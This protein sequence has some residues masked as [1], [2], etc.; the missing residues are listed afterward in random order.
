VP[1][2]KIILFLIIV[3]ISS[4][5]SYSQSNVYNARIKLDSCAISLK[6][7]FTLYSSITIATLDK[8]I[9]SPSKYS[10]KGNTIFFETDFCALYRGHEFIL[11]Y[12]YYT[13]GISNK[14]A[15]LD[16]AI[17]IQ[18]EKPII[19]DYEY[20]FNKSTPILD[21][22]NMKYAGSFARG[23]SIGNAQSLVLNS[24]FD[25]QLSG[26]IGNG[27]GIAAAISD[28]NIPIQAD[29]N[30]QTLQEF[31]RVFIKL[32][33]NQN[34]VNAGDYSIENHPSHFMRYLK[35]IKGLGVNTV[36]TLKEKSIKTTANIATS[37]G[38]FARHTL[39]TK[40]GNQGPYRLNGLNNERFI[41]VLSG[42]EKVYLNGLLLV[43]GQEYDYVIDYNTAQIT[44]TAN[45][46]ITRESRIIVEYE[47]TDQNYYR[48]IYTAGTE[49]SLSPKSQ[50]ILNLYSEQ[51]SKKSISQ[52]ELDT[53]E[54]QY[55][56][57]LQTTQPFYS[58]SSIRRSSA[59]EDGQ[60]KY[61]LLPNP[62]YPSDPNQYILVYTSDKATGVYTSSFSE[63][64]AEKGS[65][66]IDN[67]Q[68]LNGRVYKYVGYNKGNY[69][70]VN[71]LVPPE[72]KQMLNLAYK[73]K[74]GKY[75]N[76]YTD[77]SITNLDANRY[78]TL[79]NAENTGAAIFFRF[80]G[81]YKALVKGK[82]T[83]F[84]IYQTNVENTTKNFRPLNQYRTQEFARDW[85]YIK[86]NNAPEIIVNSFIGIEKPNKFKGVLSYSNFQASNFFTGHNV[87]LDLFYKK[88]GFTLS[89]IPTITSSEN[90]I[91]KGVFT[92]PNFILQQKLS[93]K[94]SVGV[95][96]ESETNK[97]N[98]IG[99][100]TLRATSYAF[101]YTKS[102][103]QYTYSKDI[104]F[105][106]SYNQRKDLF[107]IKTDLSPTFDI[108]EIE[109]SGKYYGSKI[110]NYS[111]SLKV[112]DYKVLNNSRAPNESSKLT[113]L[114]N[115]DHDLTLLK[116]AIAAT[117]N[118]QLNSGQEPK[119]EYVYQKIENL[120]GEYVYVGSDTAKIKNLNDFR[121]DPSNPLA[122]YVRFT[123]PNNEF[124][125]TNN[126]TLNHSLRIEPS[127][128]WAKSEKKLTKVQK[129]ISRFSNYTS[130][131]YLNKLSSNSDAF[132]PINFNGNDT[133]T[134]AYSK[135]IISTL[136]YNRGNPNFDAAFVYR[137]NGAK[138]NQ[139]NGAEQRDFIENEFKFRIKIARNCD[140]NTNINSGY[141]TFYN[142]L[143][144]EREYNIT[145]RK[146]NA[147]V[148]YRPTT[149]FRIGTN[150]RHQ[151]SNQTINLLEKA[152]INEMAFNSNIRNSGNAAI[153]FNLSMVHI[154]YT[155]LNN[156]FVAYDLLEGL[157]AGTN[158][159]WS[160]NVTKR[161]SKM[162]D[163]ILRYEGRK[164]EGNETIHV[165]N[166]QAKA[167]F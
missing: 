72:Q 97:N 37:R 17:Q 57:Q 130:V 164:V 53:S 23:F 156:S 4:Y 104:D 108:K 149:K 16:T 134:V 127:L 8:E 62:S 2:R 35:K 117:T 135:N 160:A 120:R 41:I 69:D 90:T 70:P 43:R 76:L 150:Y 155:G 118:Y 99:G 27:I 154:V 158:F 74:I 103:V 48:T 36:T 89:A 42:T 14:Y 133:A 91:D 22:K 60:I 11:K 105:R 33:K 30:T 96:L 31:D 121:Y 58:I 144:K 102:Y 129:T 162:V 86:T 114:G 3:F 47:Y 25:M 49:I 54:I 21:E 79:D 12:R 107:A 141:K 147:E 116:R 161:M 166:I 44:F 112:R 140:F 101:N 122:S 40:E 138:N 32:Y 88:N 142:S 65:Y 119:L 132:S 148:N 145:H 111:S 128:Y 7:K 5:S 1:L 78:S 115:I 15:L 110:S 159:L 146:I 151:Q 126:L 77:L 20:D 124:T 6:T 26:D 131:R 152:T 24:R 82:D 139:I 143:F 87:K 45:K 39:A 61:E 84:I 137:N 80:D 51:D 18:Q 46:M 125:T 92:R 52:A 85:N 93:K 113:I 9:I 10:V 50:I 98:S 73:Q 136:N 106:L 38:K 19:V 167:T 165:G 163:I 55:L 153:D 68:A 59:I 100:D 95:E 34:E 56:S 63:V 71:R 109:F 83:T 28:D 29:G 94:M 157:K 66:N 67:Q 64:G 81:K 123:V 13:L 75:H